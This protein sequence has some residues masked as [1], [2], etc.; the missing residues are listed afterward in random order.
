MGART[1]DAHPLDGVS[2]P[3]EANLS[4]RYALKHGRIGDGPTGFNSPWAGNLLNFFPRRNPLV[5]RHAGMST[6][7]VGDFS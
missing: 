2:R 5:I 7:R 6:K 1:Y 3:V 4:A